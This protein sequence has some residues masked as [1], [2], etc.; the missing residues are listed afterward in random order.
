MIID[1]K[2]ILSDDDHVRA[3][4]AIEALS[5]RRHE[6]TAGDEDDFVAL[7]LLIERYE[8]EIYADESRNVS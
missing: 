3:I 6:W 7:A 5:D 2:P 1:P 8:D 4:A